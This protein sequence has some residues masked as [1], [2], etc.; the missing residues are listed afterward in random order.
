M[1]SSLKGYFP[2]WVAICKADL[3]CGKEEN[4]MIYS[5]RDAVRIAMQALFSSTTYHKFSQDRVYTRGRVSHFLYASSILTELANYN[6]EKW[7]RA[8]T[9]K[10]E[11]TASD[12]EQVC[13]WFQLGMGLLDLRQH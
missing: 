8:S 9:L 7:K 1:L 5:R 6:R 11:W 13:D 12:K 10:S 4:G 3:Q 2:A